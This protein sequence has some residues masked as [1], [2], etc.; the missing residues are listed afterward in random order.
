MFSCFKR[1]THVTP[2][3]YIEDPIDSEYLE[4]LKQSKKLVFGTYFNYPIMNL[5][6]SIE[7]IKIIGGP[8][9]HS[10]DNL[11]SG[12]KELT[13]NN[14][15][16]QPL[17]YLPPSLQ[18]LKFMSFSIFSHRLDNLPNSLK[19]LE[20]PILYN[21]DINNLP[22]SIEELRIG[23]KTMAN[24]ENFYFPE[25]L[26]NENLFNKHIK[27]IPTNLKK[28]FI[29]SNYEHL[30]ELQQKFGNKIISISKETKFYN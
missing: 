5:P 12:L 1:K 8:F 4:K 25:S 14:K 7:S 9:N 22:D 23:V 24:D 28:L 27:K 16:N 29:F 6:N 26:E 15:Y 11:P 21:H 10:I 13:L 2:I 3:E 20:I 17:D 30:Q 19:L 18:I